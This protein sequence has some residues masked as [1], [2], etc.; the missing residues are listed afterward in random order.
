MGPAHGAGDARSAALAAAYQVYA[1]AGGTP[2][3]LEIIALADIGLFAN[4]AQ[5]MVRAAAR[6]SDPPAVGRGLARPAV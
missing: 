3:G 5:E 6:A 1:A 4:L 2:E